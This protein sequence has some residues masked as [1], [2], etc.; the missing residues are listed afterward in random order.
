M[1]VYFSGA[2]LN[3][4]G[5]DEVIGVQGR[6]YHSAILLWTPMLLHAVRRR[7]PLGRWTRALPAMLVTLAMFC[8]VLANVEA[9]DTILSQFSGHYLQSHSEAPK[10][11]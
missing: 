4:I 1:Y 11:Y 9:L 3:R 6:Y 8:C 10:H 5:A 2:F 7:R